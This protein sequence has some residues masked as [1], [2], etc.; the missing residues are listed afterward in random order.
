MTDYCTVDDVKGAWPD[1]VIA[2]SSS[3]YDQMI[4]DEITEQSRT[5]DRETNRKPGAFYVS[6]D[7][8]RYFDG[9]GYGL[10]SPIYG[11]KTQRLTSGYTGAISLDIG[12]MAAFPTSV[13]MA[14]G[15]QIDTGSANSNGVY[16]LVPAT[17]YYAEPSNAL[18]EGIPIQKLTLDIVNGTTRVW[19]PYK[20]GIKI[21]GRFGFSTTPPDDVRKCVKLMVI[22]QLRKAQQN[23]LDVATINDAGQIMSAAK[24]D[25][26][27]ADTLRRYRRMAI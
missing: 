6:A 5:F 3:P 10:F 26:D 13:S 23:W 27:I 21:V 16:T 20:R 14:Q 2:V 1:N 24:I 15:A 4:A 8:T 7:T 25:Y 22:R 9:P 17:D 12:Q 11:Y 18:E 19:L